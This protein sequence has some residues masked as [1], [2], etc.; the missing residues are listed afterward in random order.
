MKD[1]VEDWK[2][3]IVGLTIIVL[4]I[5]L[6]VITGLYQSKERRKCLEQGYPEAK[7]YFTGDTYCANSLIVMPLKELVIDD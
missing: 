2:V 3:E 5:S 6:I 7:G 1:F 4:L